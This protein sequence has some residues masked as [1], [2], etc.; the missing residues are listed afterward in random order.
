MRA[1]LRCICPLLLI[2]LT[3]CSTL[4]VYW[5]GTNSEIDELLNQQRYGVALARLQELARREPNNEQ[6]VKLRYETIYQAFRYEQQVIAEARARQDEGDWKG[7]LDAMDEALSRFPESTPLQQ[8]RTEL[9][10][11]QDKRLADLDVDLML[12]RGSWL[13]QQRGVLEKRRALAGA[14]WT[15]GWKLNDINNELARLQP[16]LIE[17]GQHALKAGK[18]PV[19]ERCFNLA[20]RIEPSP[21]AGQGLDAIRAAR[22]KQQ[23]ATRKRQHTEQLRQVRHQY[24]VYLAATR[25]A[26]KANDLITARDNLAAARAMDNTDPTF[27]KLDAKYQTRHRAQI[28]QWLNEGSSLYRR[29]RFREARDLWQKVVT[30]DPSNNLAQ[31]R[32]DRANRVIE[33]LERLRSQQLSDPQK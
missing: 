26:L 12:A 14:N 28:E 18:H 20:Q 29:G 19:A 31:A 24:L 9:K 33:K 5:P 22:D 8:A 17:Q 32:L 23:T 15:D 1:L 4:G 2:A 25:K 30:L 11:A 27:Q 3:G 7:A 10:V 21:E 6:W 16:A 13:L